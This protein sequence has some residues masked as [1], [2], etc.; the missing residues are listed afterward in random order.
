MIKTYVTFGFSHRHEINGIVY[1]RNCV[2]L[3]T[4]NSEEENRAK[5][6]ELFDAKFCFTHREEDITTKLMSYFPRGIIPIN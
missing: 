5:A 2:A 1:D 4:G 6:F 3:I